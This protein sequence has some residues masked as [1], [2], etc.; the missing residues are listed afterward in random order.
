MHTHLELP[1]SYV[2]SVRRL[3]GLGEMLPL[4]TAIEHRRLPLHG[5][6][7][8]RSCLRLVLISY[9]LSIWYDVSQR[10]YRN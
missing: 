10:K 1:A 4:A 5:L 6:L 7:P 8:R 9:E 2:V 3:A